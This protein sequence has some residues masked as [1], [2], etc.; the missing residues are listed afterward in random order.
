MAQRTLATEDQS[1][2]AD[3]ISA[4]TPATHFYEFSVM[5]ID[6]T[7]AELTPLIHTLKAAV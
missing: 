5:F 2:R 1:L 7:G 4:I 6:E 3:K